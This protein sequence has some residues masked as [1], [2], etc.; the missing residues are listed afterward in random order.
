MEPSMS[1]D[2]WLV[3]PDCQEMFLKLSALLLM[4]LTTLALFFMQQQQEQARQWAI[5]AY[6]LTLCP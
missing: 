1:G 4:G 6:R 3:W 5:G 2:Q